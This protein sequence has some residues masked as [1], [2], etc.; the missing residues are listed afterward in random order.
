MTIAQDRRFRRRLLERIALHTAMPHR[1]VIAS[2]LLE[3]EKE[4]YLLAIAVQREVL[5]NILRDDRS[6]DAAQKRLKLAQAS[7]L[8]P[9]DYRGFL[10]PPVSFFHKPRSTS[11][12]RKICR[13]NHLEKMWHVMARDLIVAQHRPR[14]HIGDWS[15]RGRDSQIDQILATLKSSRQA[16]VSADIR[17][18]FASVNIDAV[19]ELPYLPEPL[20]RGAID[21]RSHSF[22]RRER[23]E[24]VRIVDLVSRDNH[25][26]VER[27]PS[28]L[29]EGSPAS[30]A[31]FS[32]LMDDLPSHV[33]ED[34]HVFV[35]CDNIVLIAP[36]MSRAQRAQETLARYLSGHPAGP[37]DVISAV[38]SART[39]FDHLGYSIRREP[40]SKPEV[41]LSLAS[42][43][44]FGKN[45]EADDFEL[46]DMVQWLSA[47]YS[48]CSS[49]NMADLIREINDEARFRRQP[50]AVG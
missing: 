34:I 31:I 5:A 2:S 36:S 47:S 1:G 39:H 9:C 21:Y 32:V 33:G 4:R 26:E 27:C 35:Y 22:V 13:F 20:I 19:Y 17:Q 37:F 29:L 23:S 18:A 42:W 16:V 30:N 46:E 3:R 24:Y 44:R 11:G 38:T 10:A 14:P 45:L 15:G 40:R 8:L 6:L 25:D 50:R 12:L 7:P 28:G 43:N 48:R 49:P 41:S